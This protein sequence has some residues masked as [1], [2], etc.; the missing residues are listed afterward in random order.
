MTQIDPSVLPVDDSGSG[1]DGTIWDN[2]YMTAFVAA[3][4]FLIHSGTNPTVAPKDAIDKIE[5][6]KGSLIDLAARLAISLNNDGT[7][8]TNAIVQVLN[9]VTGPSGVLY[10]D[11]TPDSFNIGVGGFNLQSYNLLANTVA[12]NQRG[13]R[14]TMYGSFAANANAK[15]LSLGF[16]HTTFPVS[17]SY[18]WNGINWKAVIEIMR[19]GSAT[20]K[21]YSTFIPDNP[22]AGFTISNLIAS[23]VEDFTVD[24]L[25]RGIAGGVANNDVTCNVFLVERLAS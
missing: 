1:I 21:V 5:A 11:T 10:C 12:Q 15:S 17:G 9:S 19:T 23:G 7:L 18:N 4:D 16:G 8:T 13:I 2:A 20:Q 25:V 6:A 14:V 3:I 22:T 24:N